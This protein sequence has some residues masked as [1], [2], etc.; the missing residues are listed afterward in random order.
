MACQKDHLDL[1]QTLLETGAYVNKATNV[2][3]VLIIWCKVDKWRDV[4]G[5]CDMKN[6]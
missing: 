3:D 6:K 5:T 4:I 1:V 2:S